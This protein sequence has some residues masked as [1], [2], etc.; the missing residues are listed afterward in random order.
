M[1]NH[2]KISLVFLVKLGY[3]TESMSVKN[4]C[5]IIVVLKTLFL[6]FVMTFNL[7]TVH[8]LASPIIYPN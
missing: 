4:N 5:K 1:R 3:K 8:C 2:D 6:F 7:K